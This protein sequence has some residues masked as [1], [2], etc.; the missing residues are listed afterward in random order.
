MRLERPAAVR[1]KT[2]HEHD[3]RRQNLRE[4]IVERQHGEH[5]R[6]HECVEQQARAGDREK[7]RQCDAMRAIAW[8]RELPVQRVV[9]ER[10]EDKACRLRDDCVRA[11]ALHKGD[12]DPVVDRGAN[13]PHTGIADELGRHCVR[14]AAR[15]L[16]RGT[17]QQSV[18][19]NTRFGQKL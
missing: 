11:S 4:K 3:A 6:H 8:E 18:T 7:T 12:Q 15:I 2:G 5:G 19:M 1:E 17:T 9:D 10:A 14:N 13:R 16:G